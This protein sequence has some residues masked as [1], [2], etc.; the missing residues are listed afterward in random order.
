MKD[1]DRK[2]AELAL[3]GKVG[4]CP[5]CRARRWRVIETVALLPYNDQGITL[6]AP[7]V[8]VVLVGCARCTAVRQ[9]SAV[10]LNLVEPV[11][12]KEP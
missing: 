8:P 4:V 10:Q 7:A 12:E 11:N 6:G 5:N 2:A 3:R 9:F 1:A